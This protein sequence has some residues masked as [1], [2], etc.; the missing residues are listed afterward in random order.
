[1]L[2]LWGLGEWRARGRVRALLLQPGE[3]VRLW[4]VQRLQSR[5]A[6][7]VGSP[8]SGLSQPLSKR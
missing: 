7:G 8:V 2:M 6:A 5:A 3:R 1:M 4:H